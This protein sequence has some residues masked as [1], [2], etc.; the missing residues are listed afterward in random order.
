MA[1][2]SLKNIYVVGA[3]CTGKTTLV[4]ALAL[5]FSHTKSKPLL[6]KE[7]ARGVLRKHNYTAAD[8]TNSPVRAL[9]LQHLILAAQLAAEEE[10]GRKWLISDRS[11]L[12]PV[13]YAMLHVGEEAA[14]RMLESKAWQV[15]RLRMQEARVFVCEAGT[16]WLVDDGVRLM[17]ENTERWMTVHQTF[18]KLLRE[19]GI[20]FTVV[21]KETADLAKRVELVL[22]EH[23]D[24]ADGA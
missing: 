17:P 3:Q 11:A 1:C 16:P 12:D 15:S 22:G 23:T 2:S 24:K 13:V 10:A 18:C 7:V 21:K 5:H 19:Q 14:A 20:P 4:D 6:I 8:I 9:E